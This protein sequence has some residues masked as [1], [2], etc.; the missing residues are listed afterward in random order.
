MSSHKPHILLMG[1]TPPPWHGQAVATQILFDHDWPE[2]EVHRL[3]MEYSEDMQDVGRFHVRKLKHLWDLIRKA[4]RILKTHPDCVLFYPP[5]SAKWVPFLRDVVFLNAVRHL[6]GK[7]VFIFHASGLPVFADQNWLTRLLSYRIYHG[8]D[9]SLEVAKEPVPPHRMFQA[10]DASW[11]PCAIEIGQA[12]R[13]RPDSGP[14]VALFVASLQEG[15]GVL[16][17]LKTAKS[18]KEKGRAGDFHFRIVGKWFSAEFE[19][20]ARSMHA[21]FGLGEMVDF[22]GQLTGGEKW[23]AYADADVFFFPTHYAS[24]ATPIVI[25]EALGMGLSILSTQWAGI[26]AML[27]GCKSATLLPIRSPAAYAEA[28]EKLAANPTARRNARKEAVAFY[29]DHF[30]PE[31]FIERVAD[32]FRIALGAEKRAEKREQDVARRRETRDARHESR[33]LETDQRDLTSTFLPPSTKHNAPSTAPQVPLITDLPPLHSG[34]AREASHLEEPLQAAN[35][36]RSPITTISIYLADQ[37][38]KLGRSLG[39]SRM[40]EV[41]MAELQTRREFA[42]H[43]LSSRSSIQPAEGAGNQVLPWTTRSAATRLLTDHFHP[44]FQWS[45]QPDVWYF[46]KGYLPILHTLCTPSVVTIH[47]TIVQYYA[48]FYPRWRSHTE[49]RYWAHILRHTLTHADH[50]LTVSQSSKQQILAFMER[51]QIPEKEVTVTYEPCLYESVP[52]PRA[53]EKAAYVL[54]LASREPHKRTEWLINWWLDPA[55][56]ALPRLHVVG[57]L[58]ER[59]QNRVAESTRIK[60]LPF[61]DDSALQEEFTNA[62]ALIFP[63]EI[64]G[65]GLP[66]IEAYYLGTPV[67]FVKGTSV[68]EVLGVATDVGGFDLD[69]PDSL[70]RAIDEVLAMPAE[71]SHRIGL[72]LRETYAA[73]KVADRMCEVFEKAA[74]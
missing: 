29:Q 23:Q 62:K 53:P 48:D 20:E 1:Q 58:P 49:Y 38:P 40:T 65:F 55:N 56:E 61:L 8:A 66:T 70:A 72:K 67:C 18:L 3:R 43:A 17:I 9:V 60:K 25:M 26:P 37:N 2:F 31:R 27:E 7:T 42:V 73:A 41:V 63:S 24:E 59:L 15:K 6:A 28:L 4:R 44:L 74:R 21:D 16:E 10:W 12:T 50:V 33:E 47:D 13:N 19:R 32:A 11:C 5:S 64:E 35:A 71:E 39:I 14:I 34:H 30:L 68:E 45:Q 36:F 57:S 22:V 69:Q 46:P 52:Q 51:H 54:H